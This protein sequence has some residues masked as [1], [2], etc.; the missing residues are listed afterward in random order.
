MTQEKRL[1]SPV[2]STRDEWQ[3]KASLTKG[4]SARVERQQL[5]IESLTLPGCFD[6]QEY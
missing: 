4:H 3:L 6:I 2:V 5:L 1:L